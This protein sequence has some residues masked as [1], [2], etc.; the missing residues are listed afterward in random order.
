MS[1][2]VCDNKTIS[3]IVKGFIEYQVTY[4]DGK[5][6]K[7]DF[8]ILMDKERM[9]IGQS[10]L[11]CNID[12]YWERYGKGENE[13]YDTFEYEDVE[14]DEGIVY[15]CMKCF[16]YQACELDDYYRSEIH[17]SLKKL[18]K[19]LLERLI[20]K[21]GMKAPYGYGSFDMLSE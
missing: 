10:L 2:F 19:R 18:E 7:P 15:G 16:E 21:G 8:I 1:C 3:A 9:R 5:S 12:A 14:I 17:E 6:Y 20:R 4:S 11:N 13:N